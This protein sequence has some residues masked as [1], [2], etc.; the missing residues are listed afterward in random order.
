[1]KE[2]VGV[3]ELGASGSM[4]EDDV[5]RGKGDLEVD[6]QYCSK[7]C[8]NVPGMSRDMKWLVEI[9]VKYWKK[10]VGRENDWLVCVLEIG[11]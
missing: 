11:H 10:V 4:Q 9:I 3:E 1:M 2:E 5:A 6:P 8:K 7:R